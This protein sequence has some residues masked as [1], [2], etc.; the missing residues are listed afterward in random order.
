MLPTPS[1]VKGTAADAA[2]ALAARF[3]ALRNGCAPLAKEALDKTAILSEVGG[4][5]TNAL[6]STAGT[7]L[8]G[9]GLG[10][11]AGYG[12][13]ALGPNDEEG[14]PRNRYS[15]ALKGALLG[16]GI[17]MGGS[18]AHKL[19]SGSGNPADANKPPESF[20][21]GGKTM[22][23]RQGAQLT[24]EIGQQLRDLDEARKPHSVFGRMPWMTGAATAGGV[25][26]NEVRHNVSM[27]ASRQMIQGGK[28]G[29][30]PTPEL[31]NHLHNA[32][33]FAPPKSLTES[34]EAMHFRKSDLN[35]I[36]NRFGLGTHGEGS[37]LVRGSPKSM[38]RS[39]AKYGLLAAPLALGENWAMNKLNESSANRKFNNLLSQYAEPVPEPGS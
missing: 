8:L 15:S 13:A 7:T 17:G 22:R 30:S 32:G 21:L 29:F 16:G 23:L 5:L 19:L 31:L 6:G 39:G 28:G 37:E 26:A 14:N 20:E 1:L 9:A 25:A 10:G 3:T 11:L 4:A 12:S 36:M 24:P 38:I 34:G 27:P 18:L 35:Q 2:A 33:R